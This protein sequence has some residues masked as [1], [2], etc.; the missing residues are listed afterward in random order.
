M[1][2]LG[3]GIDGL[4]RKASSICRSCPAIHA[5]RRYSAPAVKLGMARDARWPCGGLGEPEPIHRAGV[6]AMPPAPDILL[7]RGK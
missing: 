3:A 4:L 1:W 5:R 7:H 2:S 6:S